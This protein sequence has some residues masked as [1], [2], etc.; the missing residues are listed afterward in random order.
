MLIAPGAVNLYLVILQNNLFL[1]L[2][3]RCCV[4]LPKKGLRKQGADGAAADRSQRSHSVYIIEMSLHYTTA[5]KGKIYSSKSASYRYSLHSSIMHSLFI[6][7]HVYCILYPVY[8]A[9]Y[10]LA[11][12]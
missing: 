1:Y 5:V 6:D 7:I 9:L 8:L 3:V 10:F 11:K 2:P 4:A 12:Q